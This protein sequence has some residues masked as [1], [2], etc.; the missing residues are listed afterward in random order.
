MSVFDLAQWVEQNRQ[1]L[2]QECLVA[3]RYQ[4]IEALASE[5]DDG[6]RS[7]IA[8]IC[9]S[10]FD[11]IETEEIGPSPDLVAWARRC[12]SH[13]GMS[14]TDL[15]KVVS[16][17]RTGFGEVVAR[18][19]EPAQAHAVWQELFPVFD[20]V[21]HSLTELYTEA[22]EQI[23]SEHLKESAYLTRSLMH[24]TDE[25]DRALVR[26]RA[27]YDLLQAL[28]TTL[29]DANEVFAR[30]ADE[31]G[32]ALDVD[33]C[34]LWLT[35]LGQPQAAALYVRDASTAL[36]LPECVKDTVF[37]TVLAEG[38]SHVLTANPQLSS[39]ELALL[40]QLHA[41]SL[42]LAP[43]VVQEIPIGVVTLGRSADGAPFDKS[44]TT[45]VESVVSQAEI[46]VQNAGLYEE[47]R[48]LNRSLEVRV[49]SRTRE[50]ERE[51][52]RLETLYT[53]GQALSTS[54][55][56]RAG[57]EETLQR[58]AHA[59]G[60][61]HG[62]IVVYDQEV[63]T[64]TYGARMGNALPTAVGDEA[65]SLAS[66]S[67]LIRRAID[68]RASILVPDAMQEV[69]FVQE[70]MRPR[71]L[72]AS[73]LT[74]GEDVRGVLVIA[75]DA[76]R[77][78][79]RDQQRLVTASAHQIAQAMSN[80]LLY[81]RE[82][83]ERTKT[84]A[85]LQSIADGVIVN[86]THDNVIALNS[87]AE[88][89]LS[90]GQETVLGQSVWQ[91]FDVFE[92]NGRGDALAALTQITSAPLSWVGRVVETTLQLSDKII[93]ANM[94]P[95]VGAN[96]QPLGAVTALRDI[97]HEVE[98]DR[99]KSEFVSTVSHELRTPLTSIKGYSDLLFAG[100]VGP[101]NDQQK[102]FL[103]IIRNN[104]DR[105]T[106]L[107]NDLL[108]ISRIESGRIKLDVE[109]QQLGDIVHEV[110][111]SLRDEI[112][113]KGLDFE[114]DVCEDLPQVMGD[115]TRLVQIVTNLVNNAYKYT[116]EGSIRVAL[117]QLD[118]AIRLDVVDSGIG[119]STE[120][121]SKIFERFYRADTPV[122]EGRG[123]T[124][125]G[126]A[127][128]KELVE[129]HG[130][131]MWVTSEVGTGSTFTVVLPAAA[132]DMLPDMLRAMPAGGRKI[133][134]VDDERDILSLLQ[135]HLNAQG[136]QVITATTGA[137]A[138][139]KA[140]SEKPDLITLDLLLPDRHGFDVLRELKE[141]PQTTHIPV[142]VLSVA[143]DETDGYRL[144][145]LDYIVKPVDEN[146]LLESI[147]QILHSKGKIL[148]A[149]DTEDTATMLFELLSKYGYQT[150]LAAN[151]YEALAVARREQPG[152]ILLDLKMPGMDG[153][154]ALTHL[155]KDPQT[156][157]IPI[158]VM[159]AH[160][161]DPVQERLRLQEM[162]ATDFFAKPLSLDVLLRG[163]QRIAFDGH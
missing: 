32:R 44:E 7:E 17:L 64:L 129:L 16:A 107:I 101:I 102:H 19:I 117:S 31:L 81:R 13:R 27:I 43:F 122:M 24:A 58:I 88:E 62:A 25:A 127:I 130:G 146:R 121:Q 133:L 113:D 115:R 50:L 47:I 75:A 95:V 28:G 106:A 161:V 149:E 36:T 8:P 48:E 77:A 10:I 49:A 160:A 9:H 159:S 123:G 71:S 45:L 147:S 128:T 103:D 63:G 76:P 11:A 138:I 42:L 18:S 21:A 15:L 86:D 2:L 87:A 53:V 111:D 22:I 126:L 143:Q 132:E 83:T 73:P 89:I 14:L 85:V 54:L 150:L 140:I 134:V 94:T 142:I 105:L 69:A 120:D 4:D 74:I 112:L 30:L 29:T 145:A 59:V 91:L 90:Q 67:S 80:A 148:I 119:I 72:I 135:H 163:I 3:V 118:G 100:A 125:L 153:Y 68:E 156:R 104:A 98:A 139:A 157:N 5:T 39:C 26:L 96:Q 93:S 158:L 37:G 1:R 12:Q 56:V 6:L 78:F 137:Q 116:D 155:K 108:D 20:R 99:S 124:G 162:G 97:T 51:K 60:A 66:A 151:G 82:Q 154:E 23:L 38:R 41:R 55:D 109:P 34:A 141:R 46:A 61:E 152:L 84:Q 114:L 52:E 110:T 136:Y 131:R 92:P 144:G 65:I 35:D 57:L 79:D 40:D 70:G 33:H